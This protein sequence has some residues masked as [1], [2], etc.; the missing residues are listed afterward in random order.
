MSDRP[1]S[2]PKVS[3]TEDSL[4]AVLGGTYPCYRK[5][6]VLTESFSHSWNF[7]KS[8]GWMLKIFE[9]QKALF[10]LILLQ[11][12][13]KINMAVREDERKAFMQD[14]ELASLHEQLSAVKK[15]AEGYA[16]QLEIQSES[17]F[18][19]VKPFIKKLISFRT[20]H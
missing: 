2:D 10:Y 15:Y 8:S 16:L 5:L 14:V 18:E 4:K 1:F 12:G 11:G 20:N 3:P 17:D 9:R 7:S 19:K 6:M 13:F